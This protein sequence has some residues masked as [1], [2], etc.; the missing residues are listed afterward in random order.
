ML[1]VNLTVLI[2]KKI[3]RIDT[4]TDIFSSREK[5]SDP[6]NKKQ[7]NINVLLEWILTKFEST[8]FILQRLELYI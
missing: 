6:C 1:T 5:K 2:K 4:K 8:L 7:Q 3:Y